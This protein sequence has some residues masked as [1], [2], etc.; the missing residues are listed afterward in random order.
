MLVAPVTTPGSVATTTVWFP[1]GRWVD[2][3]TGATFTGPSTATLSVPLGRMPVFVR[4]G[5]IVPEQS[6]TARRTSG[7]SDSLTVLDY[8]GVVGLLQ[9]LRRRRHRARLHQGPVHRE[10]DLDRDAERPGADHPAHHRAGPRWVPG[11][12]QDRH[13]PRGDGGSLPAVRGDGER[14]SAHPAVRGH[15]PRMVLPALHRHGHGRSRS[16]AHRSC[17]HGRGDRRPTGAAGRT[18]RHRVRTRDCLSAP[19]RRG[20]RR[21]GR[22]GGEQ[23]GRQGGFGTIR[24]PPH[25]P[26]P[27]PAGRDPT[28]PSSRLARP[29]G[30]GHRTPERWDIGERRADRSLLCPRRSPTGRN[31]PRSRPDP[32]TTK[33]RCGCSARWRSW[34]RPRPFRRAWTLELVVYLALHPRGVT[35]DVWATALWPDRLMAASTLHSTVSAA[36]RSLGRSRSGR[37]HLPH[38]P[39]RPP[40]VALRHHRLVPPD[41]ARRRPGSGGLV[42]CPLAGPRPALRRAPSPDWTVLEGVAAT[43]EEGVVQLAI[44]L[45]EH[46]LGRGDGCSA[47]RAARRALLA[48]PYDERLYRLLLRAADL[49]GNPAGVEAAMGELLH[50]V[51]G[52]GHRG[53]SGR[54]SVGDAAAYVHPE[55]VALYRA[56]SRRPG[57]RAAGEVVRQAVG[58][59]PAMARN[60][61][62]K[63]VA[64]AGATGGGRTYRGQTPVNWYAALVVIVVLGVLSVV[65]AN[66]EYRNPSS[67][68]TPP[69]TRPPRQ[70]GTPA[71]PS[72]SAGRRSPPWRPTR[73]RPPPRPHRARG[74]TRRATG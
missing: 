55:T 67:A 7:S 19:Q 1:P 40:A 66:Y 54:R 24:V 8:P 18:G 42:A 5:G 9:P 60:S 59:P 52:G 71:S 11:R 48:S 69:H 63:W 44:R 68:A 6:S 36:R 43:V 56:L 10:L 45:A 4:A 14:G 35:S 32:G 50:L 41:G 17:P 28:P 46:H 39:R 30:R 31:P 51:A 47:A 73:P 29:A 16:R 15:R 22:S 58:F 13:L 38:R 62:G 65:F 3:F 27:G 74:S 70:P 61:A 72:T 25:S 20:G 26:P 53:R 37:D 12:G 21:G 34:A 64:R 57:R 2:Y 23:G 49:Q 33:S